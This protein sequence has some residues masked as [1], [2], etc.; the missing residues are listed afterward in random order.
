MPVLFVPRETRAGERRVAATPETVKKLK[1]LGIEVRVE[2]GAGVEAGF[3]DEEYQAAGAQ[4]AENLSRG[5]SG[6]GVVFAVR[7]QKDLVA[8]LEPGTWLFGLLDPYQQKE[9]LEELRKRRITAFALELLPRTTR[10]Q[11]MDVLSSQASVAGYK[12][13][14]IAADALDRHFPLIMSAAGTIQAARVVILGA[15]VAGLQALATARRLGAIV[16]VSDVRPVVKEQVES[17]GGRF[18]DLPEL[19]SGEGHGGYARELPPEWLE[20]QR[21]MLTERIALA[22][23]VITTALVPGKRAP[24]LLTRAMVDRLHPGSVVVDVA[25]PQGGNCELTQPGQVVSYRGVKILGP[26]NLPS[27]LAHDA[28]LL[29]ARNLYA[30]LALFWDRKSGSLALPE[31]DDIVAATLLTRDGQLVHPSFQQ[32]SSSAFDDRAS[33]PPGFVEEPRSRRHATP[34]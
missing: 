19:P 15:G 1:G 32:E 16:E 8:G 9:L 13:V 2:S 18:I 3:A 33:A 27:E 22:D 24:V 14:L 26:L 6:A 31:G 12:A 20:K 34:E 11:S 10:A 17:L 29:F 7:P 28:S 25:A 23:V 5:A 21:A 30:M 4:L